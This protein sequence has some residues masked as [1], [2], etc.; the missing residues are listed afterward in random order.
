MED[1][2]KC[3]EYGY[4]YRGFFIE[5]KGNEIYSSKRLSHGNI[6]EQRDSIDAFYSLLREGE[7]FSIEEKMEGF[8][9]QLNP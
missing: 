8:W 4:V 9:K 2:V 3:K 6:F 7:E 1:M 5:K